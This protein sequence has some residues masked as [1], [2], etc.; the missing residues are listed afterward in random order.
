MI[1]GQRLAAISFACLAL[2]PASLGAQTAE[3]VTAA[4]PEAAAWDVDASHSRIGFSVR[5]FFTPVE[6]R[7]G[8]YEIDLAFDPEAP[9]NGHVSVSV[10]ASS[11]DTG[12]DR[13][14]TDLR[15][16]SF[17]E[18]ER[19]PELAFESTDIERVS[20]TEF[21]VHGD[22]TI[23][24]VTRPIDLAVTLLGIRELEGDMQR[25]GRMIAGF[26]AEAVIDRRDFDIGSGRWAET[27]VLA[28]EVTIGILLETRLR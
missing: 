19:F 11:V 15:G 6:G 24:G 21:V 16:R 27:V 7:F 13:R 1:A 18:V 3:G 28:P 22:L 10:D 23:R 26:E 2:A 25:H 4:S 17:F 20:D 9:E 8:D 12:N 5:H 14:D